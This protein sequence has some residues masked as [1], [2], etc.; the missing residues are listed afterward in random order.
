MAQLLLALAVF[1][2]LHSVP[3]LQPVRARLVR[4]L[5][6]GAYL[7]FYS[8]IS[9]LVLVWV[10][11][12]AL[13][14]DPVPLWEV[15]P[16]QA[17]VPMVLTPIALFL[18]FA[19]LASANPLSVTLR[20]GNS[21]PGA[22]VAITRHPVLWGFLLW[23]GSHLVPNGD[24][25]SVILFGVLLAFALGGIPLAER[26]AR[27]HLGARWDA[28]ARGTS[29]VPFVAILSGRASF[30]TDRAMRVAFV[31]SALVTSWL[32]LGG[33]AALFGADPLA[34]ARG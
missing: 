20:P 30:R 34:L 10:F 27:R 8:V 4:L 15:Q 29:I 5:G 28:V 16:W 6:R 7:A 1:L 12:S 26:R 19:G 17:W 25:R 13:D 21:P 11:K 2:F 31:V 22:I 9:V 33:H 32:L 3:A 18:L 23:A 24:L 14:L